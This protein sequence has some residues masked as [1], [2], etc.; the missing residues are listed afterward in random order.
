MKRT[1]TTLVLLL[2]LLPMVAQKPFKL[3]V[4]PGKDYP[5]Y[6]YS[7]TARVWELNEE[8]TLLDLKESGM[9][10]DAKSF[11]TT[12]DTRRN[13]MVELQIYLTDPQNELSAR[14]HSVISF[15]LIAGEE[16]TI[17]LHDFL[18]HDYSGSRIYREY[19]QAFKA[20]CQNHTPLQDYVTKH[21]K[22]PGCALF[23][24]SNILVGAGRWESETDE[25]KAMFD[26]TTYN[27]LA[28][29]KWGASE[30][31]TRR[32]ND[33]YS[34]FAY[35]SDLFFLGNPMYQNKDEHHIVHQLDRNLE[36]QDI[37]DTIA[38][39]YKGKPTLVCIS[40]QGPAPDGY[41]LHIHAMGMNLVYLTSLAQSTSPKI[42]QNW[43]SSV[44]HGIR[45]TGYH[46]LMMRYQVDSLFNL[47]MPHATYE[48]PYARC[49]YLLLDAEGKV[50]AKGDRQHDYTQLITM[51]DR[52]KAQ[53]GLP[54]FKGE[55][56]KQLT[57]L[58]VADPNASQHTAE[59]V[60]AMALARRRIIYTEM[61][62]DEDTKY[63]YTRYHAYDMPYSRSL[64]ISKRLYEWAKEDAKK[65]SEDSYQRMRERVAQEAKLQEDY[66][67]D[68]DSYRQSIL[69]GNPVDLGL[70][71]KWADM[72]VG[73]KTPGD[74]GR[75]FTWGDA[76]PIT[77]DSGRHWSNYRWCRYTASELRK[78]NTRSEN[79][80]VDMLLT[81]LPED[82][83]A[84][85]LWQGD[86]RTPTEEETKELKEKCQW[87]WTM[88]E[89]NVGYKVTGPN[90]NHIFLPAAGCLN[91]QGQ[92]GFNTTGYY[93][94]SNISPTS[95]KDA[96]YLAF[97]KEVVNAEA[98][99]DRFAGRCI[100][101]VCNK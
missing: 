62:N 84:T 35:Y 72:N 70:S 86:W 65:Q 5:Y 53:A 44:T 87:E 94:T 98:L 58:D 24:I 40:S 11:F 14:T 33:L 6:I 19:G 75:Y 91:Y 3:R 27:F 8:K 66:Q 56:F 10:R 96:F 54:P 34:N 31:L 22:E 76:E 61:V 28:Q 79:G 67:P 47:Y 36:G 38:A 29:D 88:Q 68:M 43:K 18:N 16:L 83:A 41:E 64:G 7:I 50:V 69:A 1:L 39:R 95:P 20:V 59:E 51:T 73:A 37:I 32:D 89:G 15:P 63:Y 60:N 25:L 13:G 57:Y 90:G 85:Q 97:T 81:V 45:N 17:T 48:S 46:H 77:D 80:A 42:E 78:Y 101:P 93:W 30:I 100:R 12:L 4:V 92:Y 74:K 71:V 82:D 9:Q 21:R 49:F 52:L 2:T 99:M 55:P 26:S 23:T